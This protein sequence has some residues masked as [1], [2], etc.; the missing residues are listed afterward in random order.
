M[1]AEEM[2]RVQRSDGHELEFRMK[3]D[4]AAYWLTDEVL[5]GGGKKE[6]EETS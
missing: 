1:K 2:E 4:K 5:H 6:E 3:Y